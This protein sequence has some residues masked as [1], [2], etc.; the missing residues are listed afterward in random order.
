[1]TNGQMTFEPLLNPSVDEID[2]ARLE[3]HLWALY[4]LFRGRH[5]VGRPVSTLDLIKFGK[6]QYNARL[7]ELRRGLA[8][9]GWC[10]DLTKRGDK[11]V[12]YYELVRNENSDFYRRLREKGEA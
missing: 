1:M 8:K 12:H 7:W 6:A 5:S 2:E 9:Q 11:G 4:R 10:I 3:E